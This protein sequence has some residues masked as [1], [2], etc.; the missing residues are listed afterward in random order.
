MY[1]TNSVFARPPPH[2]SSAAPQQDLKAMIASQRSDDDPSSLRRQLAAIKP[3]RGLARVMH[4]VPLVISEAQYFAIVGRGPQTPRKATPM[5]PN[6]A[7][8]AA[9][10]APASSAHQKGKGA[11]TSSSL[12]GHTVEKEETKGSFSMLMGLRLL[13]RVASE[14]D[15]AVQWRR[16]A[17]TELAGLKRAEAMAEAARERL[18]AMLSDIE[19]QRPP[20]T[21]AE[22][23]AEQYEQSRIDARI[24]ASGDAD[25]LRALDRKIAA[26]ERVL[27]K[28][29][30]EREA[31]VTKPVVRK[32]FD[33]GRQI[34][35][36]AEAKR[37]HA[38]AAENEKAGGGA[39]PL[40]A[41]GAPLP[42]PPPPQPP[43]LT[44]LPPLDNETVQAKRAR[45]QEEREARIA[46]MRATAEALAKEDEA[47]RAQMEEVA[48]ARKEWE[49][50]KRRLVGLEPA[51]G[52]SSSP[53]RAS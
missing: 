48:K 25:R 16:V 26:T 33:E 47:T 39:R 13:Q 27:A 50:E 42:P 6:A 34:K 46:K 24:G 38:E 19:A 7:T 37:A 15:P 36:Y 17:P 53:T 20:L 1:A 52:T 40:P 4:A 30:A 11:T 45:H 29:R 18:A 10:A 41:G 43:Q 49:A 2:A 32:I 12:V 8:S 31:E 44:K 22:A 51:G 21:D 28:E 9:A 3:L 5:L 23:F 14:R 35:A